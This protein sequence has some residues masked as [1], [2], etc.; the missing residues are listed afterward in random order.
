VHWQALEEAAP[1]SALVD[2]NY[3][4]INLSETAGR[5]LQPPGGPLT[6]D[7]TELVRPCASSCAPRCIAPSNGD[8][9]A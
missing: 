4:V 5:Y 6:S 1:P 9:G 2:E 8:K 3:H 7:I